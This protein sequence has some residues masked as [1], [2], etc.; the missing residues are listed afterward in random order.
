MLARHI[1][2]VSPDS[3]QIRLCVSR[4]V[5]ATDVQYSGSAHVD[6]GLSRLSCT[7]CAFLRIGLGND[8]ITATVVQRCTELSLGY[9]LHSPHSLKGSSKH[10]RDLGP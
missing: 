3:G 4:L 6:Y 8:S 1:M 10:K 2:D 5:R 7:L 9:F